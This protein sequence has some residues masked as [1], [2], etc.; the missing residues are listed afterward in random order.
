M[1]KSLISVLCS[2][3]LLGMAVF[4][5]TG[6]KGC[7]EVINPSKE[8]TGSSVVPPAP[9]E[10]T[11]QSVSASQIILT[12]KDNSSERGVSVER[13]IGS[14]GTYT[15]IAS[16]ARD[17]T[18]YTDSGLSANTTYYYRVRVFN[19]TNWGAYSNE[20]SVTTPNV[21]VSLDTW[22][23]IATT[24]APTVRLG[25]TAVWADG[26]GM[27]IYGGD[28]RQDG[29]VYSPTANAWVTTITSVGAPSA[30]VGFSTLW[31]G[32]MM[33]VWGGDNGN[34]TIDTG[35]VWN[36]STNSWTATS[37]TG[38]PITRAGHSAIWTGNR[39]IIWGGE[40]ITRGQDTITRLQRNDGG[41]YDLDTNTWFDFPNLRE[42][43]GA[44]SARRDHTATWSG[45]YMLVW[46]G[47]GAPGTAAV[48]NTGGIY[49]PVTDHWI[50]QPISISNA[51][52]PRYAHTAVWTGSKML[53]WGGTTGTAY[54]NDGG[55][56]DPVANTWTLLP[57][58]NAPSARMYHTAVWTGTKMII[59]GGANTF[60]GAV[61][62][63]AVYRADT[64]T[65]T[66][67]S[68]PGDSVLSKRS[69]HS[70]VWDSAS[71]SM[72]IWGGWDS[73]NTFTNG[74]TYLSD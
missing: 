42:A 6:A 8:D 46:G 29:A 21:G 47:G 62:S 52:T 10:L 1:R 18:T 24:G 16:L 56:Y 4:I 54:L 58:T 28:Y 38:V 70:A 19:Y 26:L 13:K 66:P 48:Y 37:T 69:M 2:A 59:W 5:N 7:S 65:W 25:H 11:S 57:D 14:G 53:V 64:N 34:V 44:P 51:P 32:T 55:I 27:I 68:T 30:R 63:G 72:I 45:T 9:S 60:D 12:W 36:P 49:S 31:S 71:K 74:A 73:L 67:T 41:L 15:E 35:G 39:M 20:I 50:P 22:Q 43:Y 3:L 33:I 17:V 23:S 40:T 61:K